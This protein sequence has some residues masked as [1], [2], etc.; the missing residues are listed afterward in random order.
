MTSRAWA[1][2]V[3]GDGTAQVSVESTDES[4]PIRYRIEFPFMVGD[5]S[6]ADVQV[7]GVGSLVDHELRSEDGLPVSDLIVSIP[8]EATVERLLVRSREE[9]VVV[10]LPSGPVLEACDRALDG[11]E[12]AAGMLL[13]RFASPVEL[14]FVC[15]SFLALD[16]TVELVRALARADRYAR[17][18]LH[19]YR[20]AIVRGAVVSKAGLHV[21]TYRELVA[22]ADGLDGVEEIGAVSV[23]EAL[24]DVM[25][26]VAGSPG[27]TEALLD[28][29]GADFESV[30]DESDGLLT[31]CF[32]AQLACVDGVEAA[33]RFEV[34]RRL[35]PRGNY[36][37]RKRAVFHA[38]YGERGRAWR[39]LLNAA[40][41]QS[42][43][44]IG[45][46]LA[47][48]L[49]W[50]GEESRTDSRMDELLLRGAET[51]A[52]HKRLDKIAAKARY[53][54][55][56][57]A[58]HRLRAAHCWGPSA[59]AFADARELAEQ[60]SYLA[61]WEPILAEG[62]VRSRQLSTRGDHGAAVQSLDRTIEALLAA[63]PPTAVANRS[64]RHLK[65]QK[66]EID[67]QRYRSE[68]PAIAQHLLEEAR[69]HYDALDFER[70]RA[71]ID[72][73][74]GRLPP[75]AA[76]EAAPG[77]ADD[78]PPLAEA[79]APAAADGGP[80]DSGAAAVEPSEADDDWLE[81]I[82][83]PDEDEP[84]GGY[85]DRFEDPYVF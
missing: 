49:Y 58:G 20:Y 12:D 80:A 11:D 13:D 33:Q 82:E 81:S 16:E 39:R 67:A 51:V 65:A 75:E 15:G 70:S 40:R 17:S 77:P 71:K 37:R 30:D 78:E 59:T 1:R 31:A 5:T 84:R 24:G 57:A 46:V 66:S 9:P 18:L 29:L 79:P 76:E 36:D 54:R 22:L 44:E 56:M 43:D 10:H 2:P 27:E 35:P 7:T 23:V 32:L 48:A 83:Y 55:L 6:T 63:G 60:R 53:N 26:T 14:P 45:Y 62:I 8:A 4:G 34:P 64:V 61:E 69:A 74:L 19:S 42:E 50:T 25:A 47:Y 3:D 28:A 85:D 73:Q 41:R 68:A 52:A 38:D 21:R 72:R